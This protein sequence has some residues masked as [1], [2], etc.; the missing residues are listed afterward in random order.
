[1][2]HITSVNIC[3][4][5]RL[6]ALLISLQILPGCAL[7]A[8]A[9]HAGKSHYTTP[10]IQR[11]Q[12][13][14]YGHTADYASFAKQ[15]AASESRDRSGIVQTGASVTLPPETQISDDQVWPV[16]LVEVIQLALNNSEV[17]LVDAQFLSSSSPLLNAPE[18]VASVYDPAIQATGVT[19]ARGSLAAT[20]DFVPVLTARSIY[21]G[22]NVIQNNSVSTGLPA[23]SVLETDSGNLQISLEQQ[24]ATGGSLQLQ[25]NTAF[26]QNNVTPPT[27]LFP[28]VYDGQLAVEFNQPLW[29]GA[30]EFF[31]AVAGPIDLISTRAPS[32]NQGIFIT[33]INERLSQNDFQIA[34]RQLIKDA[35]DVYQELYLAH[36][37][38]RIETNARDAAEAIWQ[39]LQAK[40]A[41]GT[42]DGLAAEAQA[43]ENYYAAQARV[44]DV[45]SAIKLTENRLR[46][47]IGQEPGHGFVIRPTVPPPTDGISNDWKQSLQIAFARR[48][49]LNE[50]FLS[51]ESLEMQRSASMSLTKPRLDLVSNFHV[52]GFGDRPFNDSGRATPLRSNSYY[53]NLLRAERT[54]WFAGLQFSMPLD[55]RLNRSLQHQLE[56]RLAKSR[57][58]LKAQKKEISH[59][60]W[61]AFRS[62]ERWSKQVTENQR[63][64]DAARRQVSA[65]DAAFPTGRVSVDRLV[66]AQTTLALA[67]T[68]YARARSE[69]NKAGLEIHFR[70]GTL[71]EHLNISM[72]NQS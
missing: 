67:E 57:A 2:H 55:G 19:G 5:C 41:A 46:R 20:S 32:V 56:Y 9:D 43:E 68:D 35:S 49:E 22:D 45:L 17:V 4:S 34:L 71:L 51:I 50:T 28:N 72:Q 21:G 42:G 11:N 10:R 3:C 54:G 52:N 69:Y 58:A 16:S 31:T 13:A 44:K 29:G 14:G 60:L 64:V 1:M 53:Q 36:E 7:V 70:R 33:R 24:L 66:R 6:G 47:L 63:R 40:S 8:P 30:G 62:N 37:R 15:T 26:D 61:H 18:S 27:N 23:G 38:Y 12:T 25:H 48:P 39:R 65:L 59:E